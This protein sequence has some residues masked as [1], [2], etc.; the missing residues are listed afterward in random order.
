MIKNFEDFLNEAERNT[1]PT[2]D[3]IKS[4]SELGKG[5]ENE[6]EIVKAI[7]TLGFERKK[8]GLER[9]ADYVFVDPDGNNKKYISFDSGYVRY[10]E[11]GTS[12]RGGGKVTTRTPVSRALLPDVKDRLLLILR[13]ALKNTGL[14]NEFKKSKKTA[15]DFIETK[16]G[17]LIGK[18]FGI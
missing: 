12:W 17:S 9:T 7:T 13:L 10:N 11:D 5:F 8:T 16:R 18:R 4:L 14:Y 2:P 6:E 15:K 3:L 1:E